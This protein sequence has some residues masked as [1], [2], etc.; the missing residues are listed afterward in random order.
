MALA[1]ERTMGTF[2]EWQERYAELGIPTFPVS[3]TA[4]NKVPAVRNYGRIGLNAS[5]ELVCRFSSAESFGFILGHRSRITVLDVDTPDER[6]LSNALARFGPTPLVV[7][8]GSGHFQAWYRNNGEGRHIRAFAGLPIDLLGKGV[9]VAPPSKGANRHYEIVRGSLE[10]VRDLPPLRD[11]FQQDSSFGTAGSGKGCRNTTM[12]E[13]CMRKARDAAAL[14]QLLELA[15][16]ENATYR[17]PMGTTEVFKTARSAWWYQKQGRN[18]FSA[19]GA[20]LSDAALTGLISDPNLLALVAF[21]KKQNGPEAEFWIADG[22]GSKLEWSRRVF[23]GARRRA[24]EQ[25]IVELVHPPAR[26]RPALYRWGKTYR[27]W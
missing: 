4:G 24:V 6:I 16:A 2:G 26:G 22:L 23:T 20:W 19:K 15:I 9:L 11:Y 12:F 1:A 10:A 14:D 8:S 25:E 3:I 7:R 18:R 13:Y 27:N 17:P 5:H 21:L